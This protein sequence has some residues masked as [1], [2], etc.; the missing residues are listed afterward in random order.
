MTQFARP[1]AD[2]AIGGFNSSGGG[3][4]WQSVDDISPDDDTTYIET[5]VIFAGDQVVLRL[6][7]LTDPGVHTGHTLRI[8]VWDD[9]GLADTFSVW[10]E[11]ASTQALITDTAWGAGDGGSTW[12]TYTYT[13][14][15]T[16]AANIADYSDLQVRIK[17][18]DEADR[19]GICRITSFEFEAPGGAVSISDQPD[20][21]RGVEGHTASF[22]A[23]ATA[24]TGG[25][26]FQWQRDTGG[27]FANVGSVDE[28]FPEIL[29]VT[30]STLSS[31]GTTFNVSMPA[32]VV[33]NDLL[34]MIIAYDANATE[35]A[36]SG[37][38]SLQST[39]NSSA[40]RLVIWKKKAVGTE[41]GTTVAATT[42]GSHTA[43]AQVYRVH[44]DTWTQ[45]LTL[46]ESIGGFGTS[47]TADPNALDPTGWGTENTLWLAVAIADTSTVTGVP[48]N[49]TDGQFNSVAGIG[50][51]TARRENGTSSEDPGTM[52]L[53]ASVAW[54]AA[55]IGIKPG[56]SG[57]STFVT[58]AVS[59][60]DDGDL[61]RCVASD[62]GG[63]VNSNSA[64]LRVDAG[65]SV[66]TSGKA[67]FDSSM[68]IRGW[69]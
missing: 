6:S 58:G 37:W 57:T 41:G 52:T 2:T 60:G 42:S 59:I 25:L 20:D 27:G 48:A 1:D 23:G 9:T 56:T 5:S 39:P 51:G 22:T 54:V 21:A 18:G 47:S 14:S 11:V 7:D 4:L 50:L 28:F 8:R 29:S 45:D 36:I 19:S 68:V 13:L 40:C 16:E 62:D 26:S 35:F 63:S 64:T 31:A 17:A 15:S 55:T 33:A 3:A 32:T 66:S 44:R 12:G 30:P 69:W 34:L 61:Y 65:G 38:T 10:L 53:A 24:G 46:V 67:M 43:A 49:Y